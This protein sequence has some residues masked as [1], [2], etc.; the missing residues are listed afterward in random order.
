MWD[1]FLTLIRRGEGAEESSGP[2]NE[3]AGDGW[4]EDDWADG[5][6]ASGPERVLGRAGVRCWGSKCGLGGGCGAWWGGVALSLDDGCS[7]LAGAALESAIATSAG[8]AGRRDGLAAVCGEGRTGVWCA[9][10]DSCVCC[11]CWWP[12]PKML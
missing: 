12:P 3:G 11:C 1:R 10:G 5:V 8:G 7:E 6:A 4:A 9:A 2:R